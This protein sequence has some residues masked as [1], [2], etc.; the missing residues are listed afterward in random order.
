[1]DGPGSIRSGMPCAV[2]QASACALA[3]AISP[4]ERRPAAGSAVISR[5]MSSRAMAS[6]MAVR[7]AGL[8]LVPSG[9]N[10]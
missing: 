7:V 2:I 8:A 9:A 10:W 3:S 1:M 5:V 6:A 4:R